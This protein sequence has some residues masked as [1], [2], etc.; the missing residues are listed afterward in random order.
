MF[1]AL[2]SSW[3]TLSESQARA[4]LAVAEREGQKGIE[5]EPEEWRIYNALARLY[6]RA[7]SVDPAYVEQARLLVDKAVE[8]APVRVEVQQLLALQYV[9]ESDYDGALDA[10]DSY[11]ETAPGAAKHFVSLRK[12][13]DKLASQ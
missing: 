5:G 8:L 4:A 10:I 12:Q 1:N 3:D 9:A 11:V 2:R 13:I 7:A 6:H